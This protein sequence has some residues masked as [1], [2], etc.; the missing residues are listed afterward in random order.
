[1]I[2]HTDDSNKLAAFYE[3]NLVGNIGEILVHRLQLFDLKLVKV[4]L[5]SVLELGD[6]MLGI[7][8]SLADVHFFL[9]RF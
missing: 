1:M 8:D 3:L 9:G 2:E 4:G 6:L 7:Q 5:N